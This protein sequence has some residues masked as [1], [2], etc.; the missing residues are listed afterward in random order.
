MDS[1]QNYTDERDGTMALQTGEEKIAQVY[2]FEGTC[3]ILRM[4]GTLYHH[5]LWSKRKDGDCEGGSVDDVVGKRLRDRL[6]RESMVAEFGKHRRSW[7]QIFN[8]S[9]I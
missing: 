2:T 8:P 9:I 6:E 4:A 5:G 3:L 7:N 1:E